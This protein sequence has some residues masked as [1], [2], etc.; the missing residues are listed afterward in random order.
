[1]D[2][3]ISIIT[4]DHI[5]LDFELAGLGS[6]LMAGIIDLFVIVGVFLALLIG[7]IITG[8]TALRFGGAA[9]GSVF[10]AIVIILFYAVIWGYFVFFEALWRGQTPGKRVAGI[11]VV[12][13][14]GLPVGWRESALRNLVRAADMLPPPACLVGSIMILFSDRSKRLGDLLAGTMVIRE[15]FATGSQ[16][17][18]SRWETAWVAGAEQGKTRRSITLG[19]MKVDGRQIQIVERFL[20]RRDS[21]EPRLRDRLAWQMAL[22]FMKAAG[23]DPNELVQRP[24]RYAV[25]EQLLQSISKQAAAASSAAGLAGGDNA[26]DAK[27]RQWREFEKEVSDLLRY[28]KDG[29]RRMRP[30]HMVQLLE[31]Y[32]R[33]AGDL[34]RARAIGRNSALVRYLNDIAIRAH[35]ILY[36]H[37]Q[38][39]KPGSEVYWGYRFPLAVR[40]HLPAMIVS[41][42]L[43]FLP[44]FVSF[45]AVQFYPALGYDLVPDS[46]LN[47]EP[48][49]QESLHAFPEMTRPLVASGIIGNNI[50]VTLFAFGLGLTAGLGTSLLLL[51]NGVQIGAVGGWLTARGNGRSFWGWVMP[52]GGTEL[53]AIVLAGG[54]GLILASALIAPGGVRR[55]VALRRVAMDALVI[56]LGVMVML[57]F[58][59]LIEG[60]VSPSSIGYIARLAVLAV[61]LTFWFGY[62]GLAGR[63]L[64]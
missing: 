15:E 32:H 22:P 55:G 39:A 31:G 35:N 63:H 8:L 58:A 21:L 14:N 18:A 64:K 24:D 51:T 41:A 33:L 17:R 20:V 5:E 50:Q 48:A 59:G 43:L 27:R 3:R 56:E 38:L 37:I 16:P 30:D 47:F 6:R 12:L 11:R 54:A 25:C 40:R 2:E 9:S 42:F 23:Q 13:D 46:F 57:A 7:G 29:L 26:A 44:A 61:T 10:A 1:M 62:L 19:D 28:G 36:G 4:P 49:R 53:L 34:A 60:F 52:H 45:A